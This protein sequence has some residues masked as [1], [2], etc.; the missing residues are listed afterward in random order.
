MKSLITKIKISR[1]DLTKV[2]LPHLLVLGVQRLP[3]V[4]L[5]QEVLRVLQDTADFV[6]F[7]LLLLHLLVPP[8]DDAEISTAS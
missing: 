7:P 1:T 5:V 6:E 4:V 8:V 2:S 3:V